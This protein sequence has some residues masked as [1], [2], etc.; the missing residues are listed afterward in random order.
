MKTATTSLRRSPPL[1]RPI[2]VNERFT[3]HMCM[4]NP[5]SIFTVYWCYL[6]LYRVRL[7]LCAPIVFRVV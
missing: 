5:I 3:D 7:S 2:G 4:R 6:I 1:V